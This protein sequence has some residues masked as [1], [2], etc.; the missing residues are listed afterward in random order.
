MGTSDKEDVT[1]DEKDMCKIVSFTDPAPSS[2][3]PPEERQN[4]SQWCTA[5]GRMGSFSPSYELT[6][7]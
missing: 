6:C 3:V 5:A 4:G 1:W 2:D 7:V